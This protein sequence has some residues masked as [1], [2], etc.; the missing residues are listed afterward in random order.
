MLFCTSHAVSS[1]A[2]CYIL[3]IFRILLWYKN[4]VNIQEEGF[5]VIQRLFEPCYDIIDHHQIYITFDFMIQ[6]TKSFMSDE[7]V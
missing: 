2:S 3:F 1:L 6:L 7:Y 4:Q 5:C